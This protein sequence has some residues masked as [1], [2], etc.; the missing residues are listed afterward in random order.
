MTSLNSAVHRAQHAASWKPWR[1]RSTHHVNDMVGGVQTLFRPI[2]PDAL[3]GRERWLTRSEA[4]RLIWAAWRERE[5]GGGPAGRGRFTSKHI[6]RFILVGLY[7]GTRAG[8][9]CGAALIRPSGAAMLTS[10]PASSGGWP[11]ARRNLTIRGTHRRSAAELLAHIRRW[12]RLA[13][14]QG[15]GRVPGG[16]LI[17]SIRDGRPW[18][19]GPGWPRHQGTKVIPHTLRHTA[20]TWYLRAGVPV[21]KVSDYCG[22]SDEII[23][24]AYGHHIPGGGM[25]CWGVA[26]LGRRAPA[27]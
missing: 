10:R 2:L 13:F 7:T 11:T 15:G 17:G 9:V 5:H 12:H 23:K 18:S 22:V 19:R 26:A 20:I 8:A 21:D 3:P 4:A 25:A 1:R 14:D 16:R 27:T 24:A 6:A